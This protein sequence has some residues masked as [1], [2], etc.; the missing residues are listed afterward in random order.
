[1]ETSMGM[2]YPETVPIFRYQEKIE[3]LKQIEFN[4]RRFSLRG[5][6]GDK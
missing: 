1:M 3:Q 4:K 2:K 5:V 6:A